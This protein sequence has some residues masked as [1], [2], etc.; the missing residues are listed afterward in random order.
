MSHTNAQCSDQCA[1]CSVNVCPHQMQ[2]VRIHRPGHDH[3][4]LHCAR[5]GI[6][7]TQRRQDRVSTETGTSDNFCS[8]CVVVKCILCPSRSLFM[9]LLSLS[10]FIHTWAIHY[11][12]QAPRFARGLGIKNWRREIVCIMRACERGGKFSW[13]VCMYVC[14]LSPPRCQYHSAWNFLG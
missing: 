2:A 1:T 4:Q 13:S 3:R 11:F 6:A 10:G 7:S 14:N 9:N 8:R 12:I 5:H